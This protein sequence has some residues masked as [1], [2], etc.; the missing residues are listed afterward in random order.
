MQGVL[1]FIRKNFCRKYRIYFFA[2]LAVAVLTAC[3]VSVFACHITLEN[4][5]KT[6]IE[7]TYGTAQYV[8]FCVSRDKIDSE[9][10]TAVGV[11]KIFGV[12]ENGK[13]A[14][15]VL[16][17]KAEELHRITLLAG[18][19]PEN[20]NEAAVE[21]RVKELL[22]PNANVGDSVTL[23]YNAFSQNGEFDSTK[24]ETIVLSGVIKNYSTVHTADIY[25][26]EP[27]FEQL[28]A[29]IFPSAEQ[30]VYIENLSLVFYEYD[31]L[32]N[33]KYIT[34]TF[35][36]QKISKNGG[37]SADGIGITGIFNGIAVSTV[38]LIMPTVMFL[39]VFGDIETLKRIFVL[40]A[41][42]KRIFSIVFIK[43]ILTG[44]SGLIAGVI[45]AF[46]S[47]GIFNTV[48][49]KVF[50]VNVSVKITALPCI[51]GAGLNM[52]V[53]LISS[54]LISAYSVKTIAG[55]KKH[56]RINKTVFYSKNPYILFG[57]K[58]ILT[59]FPKF[60]ATVL[61][62]AV[63]ITV[64]CTS[65][66][67]S[68]GLIKNLN[69]PFCDYL[70]EFSADISEGSMRIP[71]EEKKGFDETDLKR[72]TD[73]SDIKTLYLTK[74]AAVTIL[75]GDKDIEEIY[76]DSKLYAFSGEENEMKEKKAQYGYKMDDVFY[77]TAIKGVDAQ[78]ID[79]LSKFKVLG[80]INKDKLKDGTEV[81][82][83]VSE[84]YFDSNA[85]LLLG[86]NLTLTQIFGYVTNK[87][88][89]K[90]YDMQVSVAG[91]IVVPEKEDLLNKAFCSR[92]NGFL[93][94]NEAFDAYGINLP[95]FGA[96]AY[97]SDNA[98][99]ERLNK[100][101]ARI[102]AEIPQATYISKSEVKKAEQ[103]INNTVIAVTAGTVAVL[104]VLVFTVIL[105]NYLIS[106]NQKKELFSTLYRIGM[107]KTQLNRLI[108]SESFIYLFIGYVISLPL[109]VFFTF[110]F[111]SAEHFGTV[112]LRSVCVF[113][114]LALFFLAMS[115]Y[116]K[117]RMSAEIGK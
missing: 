80:E 69:R 41:D 76:E 99:T 82:I 71:C 46:L 111:E 43:C 100:E 79:G 94:D 32:E 115:L 104:G 40:G 87:D 73:D 3:A 60:L 110:L 91:I 114:I 116:N 103:Q 22:F 39:L 17:E 9:K 55:T 10:I 48:L 28:P 1:L 4:A 107:D 20:K 98:D 70:L 89:G 84:K 72:I 64:F 33:I 6:A 5:H 105:L 63:C 86:K 62:L 81:L 12:A 68:N 83:C 97:V 23:E 75:G 8:A 93:W 49:L 13:F 30:E 56:K 36:P 31:E 11:S 51:I 96:Y 108:V 65:F 7:N 34:D 45:L 52:A 2:A 54:A 57:Y 90:L 44:I 112:I 47:A 117:K 106:V 61:C 37:S 27:G 19:M 42:R 53:C 25:S 18:K 92:G 113:A 109:T 102:T 88:P 101:F 26:P 14:V 59:H 38:L 35:A 78:A 95:Y 74:N 66:E 50:S 24:S 16:D 15:G 21:E 58:S 67:V 29:V 77:R 85:E